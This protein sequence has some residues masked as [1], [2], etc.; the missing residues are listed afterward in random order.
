MTLLQD[1]LT[2]TLREEPDP[3]LQKFVE[4]VVPAME[5]EFALIPAL[6]GS[7][8]VHRHRLRDD[9]YGEEKAQRWSQSADQSLL[10]HVI[11]A[12][13]TAWNLQ[14]FLDEDKQLTEE[15]QHL[16]CLGLTLH[17]YNK[18]CQGEEEDSPKAHKVEEILRLCRELGEKLNFSAFWPEWQD[19]LSDI[20]FLAQNTQY[21]AGTNLV[22]INWPTFKIDSRRLRNPLRPLLAFGDIA[23]H[24]GNPSD[25]LTTTRGDRLREH[26]DALQIDRKLV[27]HR[28]RDCTGL[29]SSGIHNAVLH[30]TKELDWQPILFFAQGVVYLAPQSSETPDR[31]TVQGVLWEQ[32]QSLLASKML[33]G[34]IGFKRD[35]K[36]LKVAPQTLELFSPVQLIRGL[37]DVITAKVGNVKNPATP[38]RLE[39][40]GLSEAERESL[41]PAADLRSDRLAEL[42]FL[43]QKEFFGD[44]PEFA[45]W[46]LEYL[47]IDQSITPEQTQVQA[48]GVNYGWYY[49]AAHYI[50][51]VRD[52][53]LDKDQSQE[54]LVAFSNALADWAEEHNFLDSHKSPTQD[55]FLDYL[56]QNLEITG[57]HQTLTPF[58][59]ELA[60]YVAAKTKAARQP[61]CSL[62]SGQ[63]A[64]EDQ[65]DSVV[66]FKPQQYSN[67][68]SLGGRQIKR[69]I[70]KIWS[71][72]MLIRQAMWAA[73][74]GKLED[75][76]PVFI[77]VLPAYVY[78]PQTAKA[79]RVLM[80]EL[81]DRINFWDIR[82]FWQE[83]EM[84]IQALRSY[85]W[86]KEKSE[87]GRFADSN[88]GRGEK[89]DLPFVA[90]TYT[91]T[92]GKTVT[93]AWIEP[94]F[95]AIAL[96][97]LL[98]VKV[99]AST[100]P[101]PLYSSD[102]EFRESVK[103]DGPAGFWNSLGLPNSLHLEEWMQ[104]R[105]QRLD[106]ILNRL[107]IAYALHLDCEGDPPDPRWRAF[108]NTVRDI[109]TDV[110]NIFSLAASHFRGLKREPYAEE[111]KRY[112]SYAQI[113]SKGNIDMQ[114]KLKIT[115][116]LVTEYRQF[117]KVH[118]SESS[119]AILLPLSKALEEILSVPEDWDDEEL[120]LQGAGQLQAA[121]D[122]QEIYKRP[123]LS[124]KSIPFLDRKIQE[125]EAIEAFMTT[126][127][128]DLFGEMCKG[129]RALLQENRNR[130][131][132]G[133][134][135]A[136][137]WLT[138][139]ESQ[140][141]ANTQQPEGE[142]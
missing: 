108:A 88:Y 37:P 113:W 25:I 68:N 133:A 78:S 66:L 9:L 106:E 128:K 23:V 63:F 130:I 27:Y 7:E 93:D 51:V 76:R 134:E 48:G 17:D 101:A 13:L 30:F 29:L 83:H 103:L 57:W 20:G 52:N 102:S 109:M 96:P 65:M 18:Y 36:G 50:A 40:L 82:K 33:T 43:A 118:L 142:E 14:P 4:T 75:Q 100:S 127:V 1:L 55:I 137:R 129:D 86:L 49:A 121:L 19:Y 34:E 141:Q 67:K 32:I 107:L 116:Q 84:D 95:L 132:S 77:Y 115:N 53:T 87:E 5:R 47:G 92:R 22:S 39:S 15:E 21:K 94:A 85:P 6:G 120:I 112:W 74:A 105:V 10:V 56:S 140:S 139:Q 64:S 3:V 8:A 46:V 136:Y 99:V 123:I 110:L 104:G 35:G 54:V 44:I 91:T 72:E 42:I 61:I 114:E 138:L 125:L 12:I 38:K 71:L 58:G 111:V 131:K 124:D 26:L 31:D 117:Y 28:L 126:C 90:I 79:I 59:D 45:P 122:R 80:D 60:G 81:K 119:H 62:S 73:P 11:N 89:R 70:S 16:L 135:F 97:L 41:E 98:G 24:M 69:G 2:I